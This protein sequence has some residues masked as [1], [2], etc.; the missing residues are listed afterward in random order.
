MLIIISWRRKYPNNTCRLYWAKKFIIFQTVK[1]MSFVKLNQKI[2]DFPLGKE[3][4]VIDSTESLKIVRYVTLK[5]GSALKNTQG[6]I[7]SITDKDINCLVDYISKKD[8]QH[9]SDSLG[10]IFAEVVFTK[11]GTK[12]YFSID[13]YSIPISQ[14]KELN[15]PYTWDSLYGKESHKYNKI[16]PGS[17]AYK[18][19]S[20]FAYKPVDWINLN[21]SNIFIYE[22]KKI[23][24]I[25]ADFKSIPSFE[26]CDP[27]GRGENV[28][29]YSVVDLSKNI[30]KAILVLGFGKT[31]SFS[32]IS[33]KEPKKCGEAVNTLKNLGSYSECAIIRN[34]QNGN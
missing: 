30:N 29:V 26:S 31:S 14:L 12:G 25:Y 32:Q 20:I 6:K 34:V 17:S 9:I 27:L 15:S 28:C 2:N 24:N 19:P 33:P 11:D 21:Y 3:E 16:F 13:K 23:T 10:N 8:C 18:M 4:Y 5:S 1:M 7:V 22:T